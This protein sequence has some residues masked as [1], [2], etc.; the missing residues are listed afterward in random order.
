[1]AIPSQKE[2]DT[3]VD[4]LFSTTSTI[5]KQLKS[6]KLLPPMM[7][8]GCDHS[9]DKDMTYIGTLGDSTYMC[10]CG[11][12]VDFDHPANTD[13]TTHLVT[14]AELDAKIRQ[15]VLRHQAYLGKC[16]TATME[17]VAFDIERLGH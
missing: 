14:A 13:T 15:V 1:M 10:K 5:Q 3:M 12:L 7:I 2:I 4:E 17:R 11:V 6:D 8:N 9:D 16:I